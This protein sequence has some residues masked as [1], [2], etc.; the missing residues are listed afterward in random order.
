[1][2]QKRFVA[3]FGVDNNNQTLANIAN[4]VLGT[5]AANKNTTDA[6]TNFAQGAYTIANNAQEIAVYNFGVNTT[7]NTS[8]NTLS[9]ELSSNVI[10][11]QGV[12]DAQNA[13][14]VTAN[15]SLKSYTDSAI[16]TANSSMKSYVDDKVAYVQ[17]TNNTQNTNIQSAWDS[18]NVGN[19]FVHSGGLVSGSITLSRDLTIQGNLNVLGNSTTIQT[20]TIDVGDP[21]IYLANNNLYSDTVDIGIV[22][23][24]NDG[25]DRHAGIIRDPNLKEWIFFKNYEPEV[26]SNNLINIADPSFAHANLYVEYLK[27]NVIAENISVNGIDVFTYATNN[28]A[29]TV[30]LQEVDNTQNN[31]ISSNSAFTQTAFDAANSALS[32]ALAFSIALG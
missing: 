7:Q 18:A 21:L 3:R 26:Q 6:V 19:T 31:W 29:N 20:S 16:T 28:S 22:A 25:V 12:N 5:D 32:S 23:H 1:M 17:D 11:I 9:S 14:I 27:G 8:I 2:T 15:N 24:Y 30:N 10:Y 13:A 4:P